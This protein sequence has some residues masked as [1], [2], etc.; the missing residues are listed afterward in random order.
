[1]T[2]KSL[3]RNPRQAR[4]W[5]SSRARFEPVLDD[6][7]PR[8]ARIRSRGSSCARGKVAIDLVASPNAGGGLPGG[9][10]PGRATGPVP[11]NSA[12]QVCR[13]LPECEGDCL[14]PG[15]AAQHGRLEL[16]GAA[17]ARAAG[18]IPVRY[19][20]GGRNAPARRK[21]RPTFTSEQARIV[22]EAFADPPPRRA[23]RSSK[24]AEPRR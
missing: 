12:P 24:S 20:L 22:A 18:D 8:E 1:M 4:R 15:R 9:H 7:W 6:R 3:L 11:A 21:A 14:A 19:T 10:R 16:Y 23:R 5:S 13:E 2:P 17:V